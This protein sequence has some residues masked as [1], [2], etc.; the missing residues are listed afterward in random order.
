MEHDMFDDY[1]EVQARDSARQ[2]PRDDLPMHTSLA[3]GSLRGLTPT[4]ADA[5]QLLP[6]RVL[7]DNDPAGLVKHENLHAAM[8]KKIFNSFSY[9]C[10][11]IAQHDEGIRDSLVAGGTTEFPV[12]QIDRFNAIGLRHTFDAETDKT[13]YEFYRADEGNKD[14]GFYVSKGHNDAFVVKRDLDDPE[15]QDGAYAQLLLSAEGAVHLYGEGLAFSKKMILSNEDEDHLS[16]DKLEDLAKQAKQ[17]R[18][19]RA[20]AKKAAK[21]T[22]KKVMAQ[23]SQLVTEE[24]PTAP[25]PGVRRLSKARIAIFAFLLPLPGYSSNIGESIFL[26]PASVELAGDAVGAFRDAWPDPAPP[27]IDP[28]IAYDEKNIDLP[29]SAAVEVGTGSQPIPMLDQVPTI[30][31]GVMPIRSSENT[32]L[33]AG[34][35]RVVEVDEPLAPQSCVRFSLS[36]SAQNRPIA[37]A[38]ADQR[39]AEQFELDAEPEALYVCNTSDSLVTEAKFYFDTLNKG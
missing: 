28:A 10:R 18:T 26:R 11:Q 27:E 8:A 23:A 5:A 21:Q 1:I 2:A 24:D 25:I 39:V 17:D 30:A 38:A 35:P 4:V 12:T 15:P 3:G 14:G 19:K 36:E 34:S 37:F 16:A 6:Q 9:I 32:A 13:T 33:L 20:R 31:S 22:G 29:T 7:C